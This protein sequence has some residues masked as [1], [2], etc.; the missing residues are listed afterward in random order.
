M[1][2]EIYSITES[3]AS[4]EVRRLAAELARKHGFDETDMGRVAIVVSE[5]SMNLAKH[6][7]RGRILLRAFE[8]SGRIGVEA[9]ALDEGPGIS[10]LNECLRDGYSTAGSPGTGLGA[11]QRLSD[12]FDIHS[13]PGKGTVVLTRVFAR[14]AGPKSV[15][16]EARP[17]IG[18]V[19]LPKP[20]EDVCGDSWAFHFRDG[21]SVALVAD[22][23]GHGPDAATA[24]RAAVVAL[25]DQVQLSPAALLEYAHGALRPTR[26]AAVAVAEFS[27]EG[28]IRYAGVGNIGGVIVT[29]D[30]ERHMVSHNGTLGAEMRKTQEFLYP[31]PKDAL[32]IMYSD[33]ISS[34]WSLKSYPGLITRR[35]SLIAGV[36]YRDF[37][38]GR[39]DVTVIVIRKG[40]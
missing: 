9:L 15:R 40:A 1:Q 6:A 31:F 23:L 32:L 2:Q 18:V 5:A 25:H 38:R 8:D 4:A 24:S 26:G 11:M 16:T 28:E 13:T 33:G 7:E 30:S 27:Q 37:A 10:N 3:S 35:P 12:E 39:D 34:H 22:G 20:G 36:L 19:N 29:Y 21:R 17:E 14:S